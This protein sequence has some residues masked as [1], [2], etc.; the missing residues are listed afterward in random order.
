MLSIWNVFLLPKGYEII[1]NLIFL[2]Y[3]LKPLLHSYLRGGRKTIINTK[4]ILP[5]RES[6]L[7]Y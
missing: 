1:R 2:I 6:W 4:G 7:F 5:R 3:R